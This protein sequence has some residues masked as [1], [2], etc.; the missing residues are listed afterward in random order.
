MKLAVSA[1]KTSAKTKNLL[2]IENLKTGFH[3]PEGDVT[4]LRGVSLHVNEGEILALVGESGSG[5]TITGL[6]AL[7][8][9]EHPAYIESGFVNFNG[10]NILEYDEQQII[11]FRGCKVS[12]I[13]QEPMTALNPVFTI[14][15]Q[16]SEVL[17]THLGMDKKESMKKA[18]ELLKD[19][20]ISEPAIRVKN[21]PFQLSGGMRQRA[22]IAMALAASPKLLVADEPTTALDV[23]IQAQILALLKNL[24]RKEKMAILLITHDLGIVAQIADRV[25]VMYGG[26]IMETGPVKDVL[27]KRKHPYT[28]GLFESLPS[29]VVVK[30]KQLKKLKPIPGQVPSLKE[31]PEGCPFRGRCDK[32]KK[33]CAEEIKLKTSGKNHKYKCIY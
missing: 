28:R 8:L 9:L 25:A 14:G 11:N 24:S 30:G 22:M 2:S 5:K 27:E 26:D 31:M 33:E 3:T 20:G 7:K 13:F 1:K 32:E 21:Y 15:F 19:V 17:Q 4:A 29:A 18:V 16:I 23:T 6:S 12:M 10:E